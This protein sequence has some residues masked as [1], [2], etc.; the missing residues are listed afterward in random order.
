MNTQTGS[1]TS[2]FLAELIFTIFFFALS[3]VVCVRLFLSAWAL[4]LD[5]AAETHA[6]YLASGAAESFIAA[7]GDRDAFRELFL[8][9]L[10]GASAEG[11]MPAEKNGGEGKDLVLYF[12]GN[13]QL[14]DGAAASSENGFRA[15]FSVAEPD[16][17]GIVSLSVRIA[18]AASDREVYTL[19]VLENS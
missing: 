14:S 1:K 2:L 19:E 7:G 5:A 3:S 6:V 8:S 12:D 11:G 17:R 9:S 4:S 15:V 16:E 13:W 10:E 18:E